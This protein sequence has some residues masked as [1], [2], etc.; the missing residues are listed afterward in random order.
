MDNSVVTGRG[1]QALMGGFD[2]RIKTAQ[3]ML[4]EA[5]SESLSLALEM[6]EKIWGDVPKDVHASVNGSPYQLKYTPAKDIRGLYTVTHEYGVMA[7][8]DPNR[9][10]VWG[11]QALG[12]N[13]I[14]KSFLRRNLPVNLNVSEEEKVIDVEK[15]RESAMMS[16][17]AY[18]QSIPEMASQG[19]DPT[20]VISVI[21]ELIAARKKGI[22]IEEAIE[23]AFKPEEPEAS[24]GQM[25]EDPMAL[26]GQDPMSG[27]QMPGGPPSPGGA[28]AG[29][30]PQS[31]QQLLS[32]LTGQG[33]PSMAARTMR[34][35][36]IA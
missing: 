14:S 18:A 34:Q 15:L 30:Q 10:L 32:G 25:P 24:P 3:S 29:A 4:G 8:L 26:M 11:L 22:P 20:R 12:G 33:E 16:I 19:Q 7:G 28:P 17:Q 5:I 35:T 36:Q 31:M 1:V 13:L 9:A 2:S 6:D 21:S 23:D 27:G